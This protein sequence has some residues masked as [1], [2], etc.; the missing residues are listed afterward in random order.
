MSEPAA[1]RYAIIESG[2]P[3]SRSK[4]FIVNYSPNEFRQYIRAIHL[5]DQIHEFDEEETIEDILD[6]E[7]EEVEDE[8][9]E[10]DEV[11]AHTQEVDAVAKRGDMDTTSL[12]IVFGTLM[13]MYFL[14]FMMWLGRQ[15]GSG[16]SRS[17]EL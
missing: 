8:V 17:D 4:I 2:T 11:Q 14:I 6:Q 1:R 13:G 16:H 7:E 12:K 5:L 9:Q 10:E 15:V 3:Q